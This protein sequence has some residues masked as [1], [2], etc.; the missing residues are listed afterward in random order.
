MRSTSA[1]LHHN[2]PAVAVRDNRGL[3]VRTLA[4]HRHP[5]APGTTDIRLT[6]H[7]FDPRGFLTRSADPRLHHAA[8]P[9]FTCRSALSG[10][11]LRADGADSGTS[12]ALRDAAGRPLMALSHLLTADDG[13]DDH[14]QAVTRTFHYEA[15]HLPGRP[16]TVTE[17]T[18]DG[19]S[20]TAE[21]FVYAGGSAPEQARNLAGRCVSH[22]DA[23]G[24]VQTD[25]AALTGGPLSVTRRL[26][27]EADSPETPADWR[28]TGA[29]ARHALLADPPYVTLTRA[30]ATGAGLTTT[31][32]AGNRQRVACDVAGQPSGCWLTLKGGTERAVVRSLTRNAAGQPLRE[33]HG[34]GVVTTYRYAPQTRRLTGITVARPAGHACGAGVLQNLRYQ[35][36]P[37]GNV[38]GVRN[39]A[40][41]TRFWRNR[42]VVPESR[43]VYDSLYQLV[44]ATGREMA[45]AGRPGGGLPAVVA[46]DSAAC[47][48][49]VRTYDYD[50][51]GNLTRIRHDAP[52]TGHR[53]T[54][55]ITV[56]DRSNRGV[57]STLTDRP[58]E[59]DALFTASGQQ[60]QLQPGQNLAWTARNE[61]LSV[62]PVVRDGSTDDRESYRYDGGRQRILK[63]NVQKKKTG[64]ET[65]RTLYLPGLE[66]RTVVSHGKETES[67]E[68]ITVREVAGAPVQVLHWTSGKPEEI[69]GDQKR[70]RYDN[71]TGSCSL[72]L[73][74]DGNV[75]STEEYY[76][77]GGTAIW[78]ARSAVEASYK[79]VRYSRRE[80]DATGLYYH[81]YRYYQPWAGRWLSADPAGAVDG[82][83]LFRM[84]R[85]NPATFSDYD[86][87]QP[88]DGSNIVAD[89]TDFQIRLAGGVLTGQQDSL[90]Q[91]QYEQFFDN[92]RYKVKT[93]GNYFND[94]LSISTFDMHPQ[95]ETNRVHFKEVFSS[96]TSDEKHAVRSWTALEDEGSEHEFS[97]APGVYYE[98]VNYELNQYLYRGEALSEELEK[99]HTNLSSALKKLPKFKGHLLR[100]N[101]Y[102]NNE[103]LPWGEVIFPGDIV[104]NY[105]AYMSASDANKYAKQVFNDSEYDNYAM[106]Y[107]SDAH[108]ATPL[109][110]GIASRADNERE[111]L[112]SP[113]SFF[114]V[115]NIAIAKPAERASDYAPGRISVCLKEIHFRKNILA[116]NIHTG[117]SMSF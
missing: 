98:S 56:S 88:V 60:M 30:D 10:A 33:E 79:T 81:G 85:N 74:G 44:S 20:R 52:A 3:T 51:G 49:Y 11:V 92:V 106:Y 67:L 59:V 64:T 50:R 13:T 94:L 22:H 41:E 12:L 104:T 66:L 93:F 87:C 117:Q 27:R 58:E 91:N 39:D 18:A 97:D 70:Y 86:G 45:D 103:F 115:E 96:L 57:L 24:L 68:V 29:A 80:R 8:R 6:R 83:N 38:L 116:R 63:V 48:P 19:L 36:D 32:A 102:H 28:E 26:L 35:Y 16:L 43:Y 108:S 54:T 42:K 73:D 76:P 75:I 101:G 55:A 17:T 114:Q 82:L 37:V 9:N 34:N 105:P 107:F 2:T 109:L 78:T 7:R 25:S 110:N 69:T 53:H 95:P 15:A 62:T 112:F 31:D 5:H 100:I 113:L 1:A 84:C 89:D 71:L 46:F 65:R 47:T 40:Q 77:Y 21:R 90:I 111:F 61:L 99:A 4:C 23:A 14:A 72:E